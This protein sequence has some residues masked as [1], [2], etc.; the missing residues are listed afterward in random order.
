MNS[1]SSVKPVLEM[2]EDDIRM[3]LKGSVPQPNFEDYFAHIDGGHYCIHTQQR[4]TGQRQQMM[5]GVKGYTDM[6]IHADS[7][8]WSH[9]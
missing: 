9:L 6:H 5:K 1:F 3:H 4:Q 7:L 8:P 2:K